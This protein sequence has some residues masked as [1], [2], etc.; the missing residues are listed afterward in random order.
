ES[1][2]PPATKRAPRPVAAQPLAVAEE[3]VPLRRPGVGSDLGPARLGSP[4]RE[5]V[6]ERARLLRAQALAVP[7]GTRHAQA[8][9]RTGEADV[10]GPPL[11]QLLLLA[12]RQPELPEVPLERRED[13]AIASQLE[14]EGIATLGGVLLHLQVGEQVGR[15]PGHEHGAEL[16]ALRLVDRHH[17]Y[18]VLG[19]WLDGSPLLTIERLHD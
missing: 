12:Q 19:R 6:E 13:P 17:L 8:P 9:A 18:G 11:L 7:V 15:E 10:G 16:E 5:L 3:R 1:G 2:V 4:G 14:V